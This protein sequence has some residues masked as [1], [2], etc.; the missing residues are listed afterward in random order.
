MKNILIAT[1]IALATG[2]ASA[3]TAENFMSLHLNRVES[4]RTEQVIRAGTA[5]QGFDLGLQARTE[6]HSGG[7][8]RFNN[9]EATAGKKLGP[10]NVFGGLG[11][12][13]GHGSKSKNYQYGLVG[14]SAGT[15]LGPVYTFAGAKTRLNWDNAAP[16]QTS[17]FAGLRYPLT[18]SMSAELEV[19]RSYRDIKEKTASIGLR[20]G[21]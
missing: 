10:V 19:G 9:L 8:S 15:N 16:E 17:V 12:D 7:N 11:Y 4:S 6:I 1:A 3:A 21:F 5:L 2:A 13:N 18:K 14:A 20:V